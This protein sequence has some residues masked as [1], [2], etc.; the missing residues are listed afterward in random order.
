MRSAPILLACPF[1]FAVTTAT[2]QETLPRKQPNVQMAQAAAGYAAKVTASAIFIS[3][4]TLASVL[5]AEFAP[6]RPLEALIRPLLKFDVDRK[7]GMV[8]CRIGSA[9]ATAVHRP[10]F[11]CVLVPTGMEADTLRKQFASPT[12][13]GTE[14]SGLALI[15]SRL[16][17]KTWLQAP[18]ITDHCDIAQPDGS[19]LDY[20]ALSKAVAR[21]FE[22]RD[23]KRPVNTRAVVVVHRGKL[24]AEGYADGIDAQTALPGWSMSKTLTNAL[25][26]MRVHEGKLAIQAPGFPK[27]DD[28]DKTRRAATI[29]H[30]LTMTAGLAWNE[31]YD[32]ANSDALRMLFGS[33]DHAGVYSGQPQ[34]HAAGAKFQYASGATNQLCALLRRSFGK[35]GDEAYWRYP[36]KLFYQLGMRTAVLETDPSGTFVGSSY[37]YASARD[38]ARLGLLYLRDGVVGSRRLLPEGWV[39]AS[40]EA[41]K[42]SDGKYGYQVWLNRDPSSGKQR[43]WPELPEDLFHM[44]GHEGQYVVMSPSAQLVIVRLGCT[45]NGGF[46]L[47][48]LLRDVHACVKKTDGK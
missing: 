46:D 35:G 5:A 12:T 6:T 39:D 37:G 48:G 4:R 28:E 2:A 21:A 17:A 8:T 16:T 7:A 13:A 14:A 32:D 9:R 26:G 36:A 11:G 43:T 38:W 47:R 19:T 27:H 10:G 29:E 41:A 18:S 25:I 3:N 20:H 22:E 1:A 34:Q 45:K 30:L 44:D 24:I 33:A 42:A 31:D 40:T 15:Q 23:Q